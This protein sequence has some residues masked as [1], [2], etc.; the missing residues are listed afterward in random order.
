[1][2]APLLHLSLPLKRSRLLLITLSVMHGL[3]L[4]AILPS[5]VAV[6][7]KLPVLLGIVLSVLWQWREWK[8]LRGECLQQGPESWLLETAQGRFEV[9]LQAGCFESSHLV[10][11]SWR[12]RASGRRGKVALMRD[13]LSADDWRR[14]RRTLRLL[15]SPAPQ[16]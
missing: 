9:D 2:S 15:L 7:I 3:P 8:R 11:L 10:V 14:L 16:A 1:M 5:Q 6:P 12:E 4:L 13:A